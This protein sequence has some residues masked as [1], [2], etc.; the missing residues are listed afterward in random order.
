M[1]QSAPTISPT[2]PPTV[3]TV[4]FASV[5]TW[6]DSPDSYSYQWFRCN[7]S[8]TTCT[9]SLQGP[10]SVASYTVAVADVGFP[11]VVQ[12]SATNIAGTSA[13]AQSPPAGTTVGPIPTIVAGK[14][15]T[16]SGQP[17]A[18]PVGTVDQRDD[19]HLVRHRADHV[20][21]PVAVLRLPDAAPVRGHPARHE[22]LLRAHR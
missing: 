8:G 20:H 11:I 5:G 15:P 12:V 21:V 9:T 1:N 6:S 4:L 16:I 2:T 3:G 17:K 7:V 19:G 18:F 14:L 22:Q 13:P 10:S